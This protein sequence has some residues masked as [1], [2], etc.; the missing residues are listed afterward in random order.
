MQVRSQNPITLYCDGIAWTPVSHSNG[1]YEYLLTS[2]GRFTIFADDKMVFTFVNNIDLDF[3]LVAVDSQQF[4]EEGGTRLSN[5]TIRGSYIQESLVAQ[6]GYI[7]LVVTP[8]DMETPSGLEIT[9][10]QEIQVTR[11]ASTTSVR[12][13]ITQMSHE[14][15]LAIYIGNVLVAYYY[16]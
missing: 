16:I 8:S 14:E 6:T 5:T 15:P 10:N 3:N 1:I 9:S 12:L 4:V 11:S 2:Q 13:K 7:F